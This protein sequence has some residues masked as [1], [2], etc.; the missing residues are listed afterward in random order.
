MKNKLSKEIKFA[1][2]FLIDFKNVHLIAHISP[3]IFNFFLLVFFISNIHSLMI[4]H[5]RKK[6]KREKDDE[7]KIKVENRKVKSDLWSAM[8]E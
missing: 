2:N 6:E 3:Q 8:S 4:I 7:R 1:N 5:V